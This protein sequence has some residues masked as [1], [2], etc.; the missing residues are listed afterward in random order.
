MCA[1]LDLCRD[2]R[3]FGGEVDAT[4]GSV[5]VRDAQVVRST[6][7]PAAHFHPVDEKDERG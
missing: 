5:A 6:D 2:A 7:L 1:G 3:H 4:F